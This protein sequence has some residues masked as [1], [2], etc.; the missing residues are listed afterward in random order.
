MTREELKE[1][2]ERQI[3]G[4]VRFAEFKNEKPH[5]KIYEEHKLILEL[6]EQ[7]T[8][9]FDFELYKAG[10]MNMPKGMIEVLDQIMAEI[11]DERNDYSAWEEPDVAYGLSLALEIIDKY[12]KGHTDADSD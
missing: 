2:C 6:L 11:C 9:P 1:H 4:C 7:E 10:L 12:R 3:A 8:A 5:G